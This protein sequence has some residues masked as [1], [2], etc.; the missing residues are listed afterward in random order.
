MAKIW[1]G[2]RVEK[3]IETD[4]NSAR[5]MVI[6]SFLDFFGEKYHEYDDEGKRTKFEMKNF[7]IEY[8]WG[9]EICYLTVPGR[10]YTS[11][12]ANSISEMFDFL[13]KKGVVEEKEAMI[14]NNNNKKITVFGLL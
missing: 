13:T 9:K 2:E 3:I 6:R 4:M 12:P 14:I 1:K 10:I 7:F 8:V 5:K 11:F